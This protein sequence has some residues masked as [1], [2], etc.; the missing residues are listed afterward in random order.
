MF[1]FAFLIFFFK[2]SVEV[3]EVAILTRAAS[4]CVFI[5]LLGIAGLIGLS[6]GD[7]TQA[8]AD[9]TEAAAGVVEPA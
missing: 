7:T 2:L 1:S 5:L 6:P 4:T 3:L 8:E 9:D